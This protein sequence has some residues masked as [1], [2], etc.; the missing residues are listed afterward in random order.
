MKIV[1]VLIFT[2][3]INGWFDKIDKVLKIDYTRG[4]SW[5]RKDEAMLRNELFQVHLKRVINENCRGMA[6]SVI[7]VDKPIDYRIELEVIKPLFGHGGSYIRGENY[8]L[9][10]EPKFD[11]KI[12]ED[13]LGGE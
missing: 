9:L 8:E 3:D 2:D 11:L 6:P 10:N 1:R 12:F 4:V 13:I 5:I 7:I